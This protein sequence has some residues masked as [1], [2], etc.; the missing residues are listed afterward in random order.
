LSA[1]LAGL[2]LGGLQRDLWSYSESFAGGPFLSR[3]RVEMGSR[4]QA[5]LV[6]GRHHST[7]HAFFLAAKE[8]G[9]TEFEL[10]FVTSPK[11][12]IEFCISPRGHSE[13]S[14]KFDVRGNTV[15][16]AASEASVV[17]ADETDVNYRGTRSGEEP[18]HSI[19]PQPSLSATTIGRASRT[20]Q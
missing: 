12:R 19:V 13:M 15:R 10:Q 6:D 5:A 20:P 16:V 3:A 17:P 8:S 7:L 14:A 9:F 11:G 4:F 18:V 2:A 1:I